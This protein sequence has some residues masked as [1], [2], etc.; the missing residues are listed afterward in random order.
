MSLKPTQYGEDDT[1]NLWDEGLERRTS[2]TRLRCAIFVYDDKEEVEDDDDGASKSTQNTVN[3]LPITI[4]AVINPWYC[5]APPPPLGGER[6]EF[7]IN[8]K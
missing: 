2:K 7:E 3:Q 4:F 5:A 6:N 8:F 1:V